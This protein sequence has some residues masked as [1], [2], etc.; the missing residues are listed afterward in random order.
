MPPIEL[1]LIAVDTNIGFGGSPSS[2]QFSQWPSQNPDPLRPVFYQPNDMFYRDTPRG[3]YITQEET[4]NI[5]NEF[6]RVRTM[7]PGE[8]GTLNLLEFTNMMS[9]LI[10]NQKTIQEL[11]NAMDIE[12]RGVIDFQRFMQTFSLLRSGTDD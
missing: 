2:T 1:K 3:Q 9:K 6:R 4:N 11:F 10:F 12:N 5:Q 7:R 8:E